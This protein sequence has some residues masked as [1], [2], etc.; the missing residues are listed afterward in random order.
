MIFPAAWKAWKVWKAVKSAADSGPTD[1][2]ASGI[3]MP[4]YPDNYYNVV[5]L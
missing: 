1:K 5:D 3:D 2:L 4:F